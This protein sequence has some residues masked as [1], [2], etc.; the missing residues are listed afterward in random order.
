MEM[1]IKFTVLL[2]IT[3]LISLI[4]INSL[5]KS[6]TLGT[7]KNRYNYIGIPEDR[8]NS[9]AIYGKQ[10][11]SMW[12]WAAS[13]QMVLNFY[14]IPA[15]QE[16]IVIKNLGG[17]RNVAA[18][19]QELFEAI[20]GSRYTIR[21]GKLVIVRSNII[22]PTIKELI[23]FLNNQKPLIVGLSTGSSTFG[24]ALVLIGIEIDTQ[25]GKPARVTL[26]DP[27]PGNSMMHYMNWE[28]FTDSLIITYKIWLEPEN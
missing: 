1:K 24:H 4:F 20:E 10:R 26:A 5:T 15:K 3:L 18:T 28:D 6:Q 9:S 11:N 13:I 19:T 12:C 8:F 23:S 25:S 27:W 21:G 14:N 2:K 17:V 7:L 16:E 22:T